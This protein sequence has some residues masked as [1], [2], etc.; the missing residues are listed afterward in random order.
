MRPWLA[1]LSTLLLLL[2]GCGKPLPQDRLAYVGQW[3]GPDMLLNITSG[4][5]V[6]YERHRGATR[7]TVEGPL[8]GFHGEGFD[9]GIGPLRTTFEVSS[10]PHEEAGR[11]TMVVDGVELI[12]GEGHLEAPRHPPAPR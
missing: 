6:A 7:T 3:R 2:T 10:P 12:R 1:L 8:Q 11:W 9:V 4:G 5:R